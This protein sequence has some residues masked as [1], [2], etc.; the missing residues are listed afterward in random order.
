MPNSDILSL[1]AKDHQEVKNL[2]EG[3]IEDSRSE[4]EIERGR[5]KQIERLLSLHSRIE[6]ILVYSNAA[7][8]RPLADLIQHSYEEHRE[9]K[10]CAHALATE[11]DPESVEDQSRELLA[12]LMKHV[13]EEENQLFPTLR[14]AWG[15]ETLLELGA[16]ML[17]IQQQATTAR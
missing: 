14:Q 12:L 16:Q 7:Q 8:E 13:Q 17:A 6:E 4:K 10:D 9:A 5:L 11:S 15:E 1:L 3:I 2:L